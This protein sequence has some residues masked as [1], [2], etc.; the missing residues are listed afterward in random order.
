MK[1][2]SITPNASMPLA[3]N[4]IDQERVFRYGFKLG[5]IG[6]LVTEGAFSNVIENATIYTIPNTTHW[7]EGLVNLHGEMI[8]VFNL[9]AMLNMEYK[10]KKNTVIVIRVGE[11]AM[12]FLTDGGQSLELSNLI[13]DKSIAP[14]PL[15]F[16]ADTCYL[17]NGQVWVEF[18]YLKFLKAFEPQMSV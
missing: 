6:F 10:A 17:A 7:L 14:E 4:L 9:N 8:P 2:A 16:Y 1:E 3:A 15:T 11:R 5:E 12:A 13:E 18:D